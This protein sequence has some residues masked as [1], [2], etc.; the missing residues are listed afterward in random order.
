MTYLQNVVS[1][2][3]QAANYQG[4]AAQDEY[5]V[6]SADCPKLTHAVPLVLYRT[7]GLLASNLGQDYKEIINQLQAS[8]ALFQ[9]MNHLHLHCRLVGVI[10]PA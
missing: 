3:M 4:N 2:H 7:M 1:F 8:A 6:L 10:Q 9:M 5:T